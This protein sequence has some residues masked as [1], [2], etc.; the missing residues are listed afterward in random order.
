MDSNQ[1]ISERPVFMMD[2]NANTT[3]HIRKEMPQQASLFE[4]KTFKIFD[5]Y[6]YDDLLQLQSWL[7]LMQ[8]VP[9]SK[10]Q[11]K[12]IFNVDMQGI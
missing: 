9:V 3:H 12:S 1:N 7:D 2:G 10:D 5:K 8:N 11:M 6:D 4:R